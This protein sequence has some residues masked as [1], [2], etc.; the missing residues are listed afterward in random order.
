[1]IPKAP[2]PKLPPLIA[3]VL[4]LGACS[5]ATPGSESQDSGTPGERSEDD[6]G[7]DLLVGSLEFQGAD[8]E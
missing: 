2:Y 6:F 3:G 1:M 5:Q 4:V 7:Y 8:V